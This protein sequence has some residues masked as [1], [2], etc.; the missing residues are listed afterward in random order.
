MPFKV[1]Q[2]KTYDAQHGTPLPETL[3]GQFSPL[4]EIVKRCNRMKRAAFR[5]VGP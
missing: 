2:P 3:V 5:N 4:D 1:A